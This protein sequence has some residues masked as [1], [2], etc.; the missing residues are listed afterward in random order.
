MILF[1]IILGILGLMDCYSTR[2][3]I[4]AGGHEQNPIAKALMA[5]LGMD[6]F[7]SLKMVAMIVCGFYAPPIMAGIVAV[8]YA[9]VMIHNWKSIPKAE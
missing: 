1:A 8:L 5:V 3:I 9:A 4:L 2:R 6:G 7:L